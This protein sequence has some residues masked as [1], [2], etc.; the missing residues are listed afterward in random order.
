MDAGLNS[1]SAV[2][3]SSSLSQSL[4][5][6]LPTTL[7]FDYATI[8]D[9]TAY[10]V[11]QT[12]PRAQATPQGQEEHGIAEA[13]GIAEVHSKSSPSDLSKVVYFTASRQ[14]HNS[15]EGFAS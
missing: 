2:Q 6:S 12:E 9:I 7:L 13:H 5:I 8:A 15:V 4:G 11:D 10:I 1:M 3:C 14:Q